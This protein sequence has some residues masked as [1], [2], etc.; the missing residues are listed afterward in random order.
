MSGYKLIDFKKTPI[1]A[2]EGT[3]VEGVFNAIME[4]RKETRLINVVVNGQE[5]GSITANFNRTA[6]LTA[7]VPFG[8]GASLITITSD[9]VVTIQMAEGIAE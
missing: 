2:N 4:T 3:K 5:F 6:P 8:T 9:D 7:I 1:K